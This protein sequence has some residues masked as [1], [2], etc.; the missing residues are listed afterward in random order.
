M[1][2][3]SR[4]RA[5]CRLVFGSAILAWAVVVGVH[6]S[7]I[8]TAQRSAGTPSAEAMPRYDKE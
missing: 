1:G 6:P 2:R 4:A 3:R 8:V 5:V 7:A